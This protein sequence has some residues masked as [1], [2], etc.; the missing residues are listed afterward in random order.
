MAKEDSG[1]FQD[2]VPGGGPSLYEPKPGKGKSGHPGSGS[3]ET[4][5]IMARGL[6][7][8]KETSSTKDHGIPVAC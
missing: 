3:T 2:L 7:T 4:H 5:F 8:V 1:G 6:K